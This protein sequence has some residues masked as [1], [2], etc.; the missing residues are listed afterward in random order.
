MATGSWT[1]ESGVENKKIDQQFLQRC[2]EIASTDAIND[3]DDAL[4]EQE[5]TFSGIM[6]AQQDLWS[7]ALSEYNEEQL[8]SLIRFFTLA[9]MQ[10]AGWHAGSQS[11]VIAINQVL[12]SRGHKLDRDMLLWIRQNSTNRFIPNG[13]VL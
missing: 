8:I 11:P 3:L 5:K 12:K 6:H 9:E 4:T 2:M 10:L 7:S 1:P 13:A